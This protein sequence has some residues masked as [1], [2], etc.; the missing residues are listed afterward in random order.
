MVQVKL[1]ACLGRANEIDV[2]KHERSHGQDHCRGHHKHKRDDR[3]VA[4][5]VPKLCAIMPLNI[6]QCEHETYIQTA[7]EMDLIKGCESEERVVHAAEPQVHER[8]HKVSAIVVA[9]TVVHPGY[10]API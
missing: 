4:C 6:A 3:G 8:Q 10:C 7:Q 2:P 5:D 1:N 9:D